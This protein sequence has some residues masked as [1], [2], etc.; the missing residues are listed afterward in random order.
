MDFAEFDKRCKEIKRKM[1]MVW[2][3]YQLIPSR[4][5]DDQTIMKSVWTWGTPGHTQPR[6]EALDITFSLWLSP[7]K[8][9]DW[10]FQVNYCWSKS[11]A[12]WLHER[13]N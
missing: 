5:I 10:F 3:R 7:I 9:I 4:D 11:P 13:H 12:I 1:T 2:Q 6:V 8:D